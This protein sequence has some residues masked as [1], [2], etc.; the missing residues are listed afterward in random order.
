M[1]DD[2]VASRAAHPL[3]E[4]QPTAD[5]QRQAAALLA[6]SDLRTARAATGPDETDERRT[7]AESAT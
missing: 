7:S 4:E 3:P 2:R 5:A 1:S 6:E